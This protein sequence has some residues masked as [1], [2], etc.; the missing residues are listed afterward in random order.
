MRALRRLTAACVF[1]FAA[2]INLAS[3][4][5]MGNLSVNHYARLEP[6]A[7]GVEVTYV[8]DLAE[9]PTFELT[10]TWG[11]P[12][13]TS[14]ELLDQKAAAQ[15]RAW[16]ADLSFLQNGARLRPAIIST[17]L[18]IMSRYPFPVWRN[19]Y[20]WNPRGAQPRSQ[21]RLHRPPHGTSGRPNRRLWA[22]SSATMRYRESFG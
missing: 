4:H 3:A 20:P 9:L 7:H 8:L 18:D 10:Q 1:I 15:A 11:A 21:L 14:M 19:Q 2:G 5:P 22:Q 6:G 13:G 12:Q 16:V 17:H